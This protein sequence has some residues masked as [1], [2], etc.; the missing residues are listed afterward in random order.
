MSD[1]MFLYEELTEERLRDIVKHLPFY[2]TILDEQGRVRWINR[3]DP[4]LRKEDVIGQPGSS[5]ARPEHVQRLQDML[6]RAMETGESQDIE[7]EGYAQDKLERW[8]ALHTVPMTT[9]GGERRVLLLTEDITQRRHAQEQ[10]ASSEARFRLLTESSPDFIMVIDRQRRCQYINHSHEDAVTSTEALLNM[11]IDDITAPEDLDNAIAAIEHAFETGEQTRYEAHSIEVPDGVFSCRLVPLPPEHGEERCLIITSEVTAE[12]AAA[13]EAER[14]TTYVQQTQRLNAIGQLTGGIAHDFNNLLTIILTE[15]DLI[16]EMV[17]TGE[18]PDEEI[19]YAREAAERAASLTAKLLAFGGQAALSA[20]PLDVHS[21]VARSVEML[22]RTIPASITL[23]HRPDGQPAWVSGDARLIEQVLL[24][25]CLNARDAIDERFGAITV[26]TR[27]VADP[28]RVEI[29]V[30]DDGSGMDKETRARVFEPYFTT[31]EVGKGTG[32]GLSMAHGIAIGHKGT[33]TVDSEPGQGTSFTLS[34]PGSSPPDS[35]PR[36]APA[37]EKAA[38]MLRSG[39]LLVVEDEARVRQ[40]VVRILQNAGYQVDAVTNGLEAIEQVRDHNKSY[41]AV[42]LDM[43]MPV[44]SGSE[45]FVLLQQLCPKLPT[46]VVTG[47]ADKSLPE[48]ALQ[49][50]HVQLVPKPYRSHQLLQALAEVMS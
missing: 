19:G 38:P 46:V 32:L 40:V 42:V 39:R 11:R 28:P 7:I 6:T 14:L 26:L 33:M 29:V 24:N 4:T 23:T 2:T 45:A 21:L 20:Q 13:A 10:L 36:A 43:V 18:S 16:Q 9:A 49:Q 22:R 37:E 31:K 3:L 47:Y 44:M 34:L 25:L 8:Y 50:D 17:N 15:L 1:Q 12:R 35:S 41:D 48:V 5:F 30:K 27:T